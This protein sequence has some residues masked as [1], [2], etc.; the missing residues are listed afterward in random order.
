MEGEKILFFLDCSGSMSGQPY[1]LLK[2]EILYMAE[3]MG[4]SYEIGV[5]FFQFNKAILGTAKNTTN[6]RLELKEFLD[7]KG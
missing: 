4:D 1:Q 7:T 5:V 6:F 3:T 2:E